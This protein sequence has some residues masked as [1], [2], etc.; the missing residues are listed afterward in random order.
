[1]Y[2]DDHVIHG[3]VYTDG[4]IC[5]NYELK[6]GF[7]S[8][9]A[10][11]SIHL[12]NQFKNGGQSAN[13][14]MRNRDI[15]RDHYITKMAE[16]VI[17]S[18]Y[19]KNINASKVKNLIFCGPAQFKIE[20]SEHKLIKSF[21]DARFIHVI[22]MGEMDY[23]LLIDTVNK[24]DD[25]EEKNIVS[26]IR[27]LIAMTD[28]R[29]IFGQ[30]IESCINSFEVKILYVHKDIEQYLESH[31]DLESQYQLR[32]IELIK[33]PEIKK[34]INVIKISSHMIMEYGGMIGIKYY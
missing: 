30:D 3:V 14:L 31:P 26:E 33:N 21:F 32:V 18:F 1:M 8:K 15:Q 27:E 24:F 11:S 25:P 29:L 2:Q 19:D 16:R 6:Y 9:V 28:H 34:R 12:Q 5:T 23:D 10:S 7:L 20:I 13:R 4:K 17:E 22:N